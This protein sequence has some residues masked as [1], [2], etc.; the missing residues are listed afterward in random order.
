MVTWQVLQSTFIDDPI[1]HWDAL[2]TR[3]L[4]CPFEV[5]TQ[6]FH[7]HVGTASVPALTAGIDW[8]QVRAAWDSAGATSGTR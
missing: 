8:T 1:E 5:F 3:G 4:D 6:L 7:E 2:Q